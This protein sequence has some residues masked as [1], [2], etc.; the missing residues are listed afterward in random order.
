VKIYVTASTERRHRVESFSFKPL[1]HQSGV[2]TAF[3]QR[4]KKI[5]DRRGA[6]CANA[7]NAVETLWKPSAIA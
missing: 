6:R 3:P 7:S 2:I 1:L 4:L 5:A